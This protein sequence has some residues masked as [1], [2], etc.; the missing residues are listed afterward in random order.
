MFRRDTSLLPP[1][2]LVPF[3]LYKSLTEYGNENIRDM[4]FKSVFA[5]EWISNL[6]IQKLIW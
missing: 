5:V 3:D 2:S 6:V 1:L 4:R